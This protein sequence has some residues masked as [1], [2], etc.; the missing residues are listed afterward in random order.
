MSAISEKIAKQVASVQKKIDA[1]SGNYLTNTWKRQQEQKHR[2]TQIERLRLQQQV[3]EYLAAEVDCRDLTAFEM[4]LLTGTFF[5][6]MRH[7]LSRKNYAAERPTSNINLEFPANGDTAVK[8]LNKADI[9]DTDSLMAAITMFDE[10]VSSAVTPP[11]PNVA[12]I[13]DMTFKARLNQKGDVQFTPEKVAAQLIVL[14]GI[15]TD[16]KVLEP[17]A[18]IG[19]IADEARKTTVYV[20]CIEIVSGFREL[21]EL[22]G[23]NIIGDDLFNYDPQP[24]YDAVLMNPPFS[25]ECRHI[26]HAY[27][28]LKPGGRLAAVCCTRMTEARNKK[29]AEYWE[30][31]EGQRFRFVDTEE[32]FE[33]TGTNT[34]ILIIEK[35][36]A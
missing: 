13:R 24:V 10:L 27:D 29:Y 3:L 6:D 12:K 35:P 4:A 15:D 14:A 36:A 33:M 11:D 31:L 8:R 17:E 2:D 22:K 19:S 25:D 26:R 1:L 18:G 32:K 16:S 9:H 5:E 7:F 20:D 21:L 30:W 23:H 28:F 34:K